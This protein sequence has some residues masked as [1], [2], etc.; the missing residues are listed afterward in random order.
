MVVT[1]VPPIPNGSLDYPGN[2]K[3]SVQDFNR[4]TWH[5]CYNAGSIPTGDWGRLQEATNNIPSK[6]FHDRIVEALNRCDR[7]YQ[8]SELLSNP[9]TRIEE[10]GGDVVR[11][12]GISEA[13]QAK[14]TYDRNYLKEC[15]ALAQCL[16]VPNYRNPIQLRYA[17]ERSGAEYLDLGNGPPD[18]CASDKLQ[19]YR[20]GGMF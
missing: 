4:V 14:E 18:T 9:R 11:V 13:E 1:E 2:V 6:Q 15:D 17:F 8:A 20:S 7:A 16:F 5:L 3:L 19:L 10:I 12:I